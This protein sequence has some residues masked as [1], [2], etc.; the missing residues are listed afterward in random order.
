MYK[1]RRKQKSK[2][3]KAL[4][5]DDYWPSTDKVSTEAAAPAATAAA[6]AS[7]PQ[8]NQPLTKEQEAK[9]KEL[10][11]ILLKKLVKYNI[12]DRHL[13]KATKLWNKAIVV[14]KNIPDPRMWVI[15]H[16][17]LCQ[18]WLGYKNQAKEYEP[19]INRKPIPEHIKYIIAY[20]SPMRKYMEYMKAFFDE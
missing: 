11:M 10:G 13:S 19:P 18:H 16:E 6:A 3:S 2:A 4:S 20:D 7:P 12:S 8:K 14:E 1:H 5:V 17:N 15:N 9:Q